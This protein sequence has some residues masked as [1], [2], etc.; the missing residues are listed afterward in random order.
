MITRLVLALLLII[1]V[2]S[3]LMR[4]AHAAREMYCFD[5]LE[6]ASAKA[7]EHD[8]KFMFSSFNLIGVEMFFFSGPKTWTV[9]IK[10]DDG[11]YCTSPALLGV[12]K[13]KKGI[14]T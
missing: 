13:P 5:N 11:F 4:P 9:F 10:S 1:G 8:E 3:F 6:K 12:I 14:P 7:E 2:A